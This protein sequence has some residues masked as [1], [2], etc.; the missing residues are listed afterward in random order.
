MDWQ[1]KTSPLH[2]H[3]LIQNTSQT[4][5]VSI[6]QI[7][8]QFLLPGKESFQNLSSNELQISIWIPGCWIFSKLGGSRHTNGGQQCLWSSVWLFIYRLRPR[9]TSSAQWWKAIVN[10]SYLANWI[11]FMAALHCCH[12]AKQPECAGNI[13]P[14]CYT[15]LLLHVYN[16][17][18]TGNIVFSL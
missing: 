6:L 14:W 7:I 1:T 16:V 5:V 2:H 10:S 9:S 15:Y 12:G 17:Y 3:H 8:W 4:Q 18:N 13:E 11:G